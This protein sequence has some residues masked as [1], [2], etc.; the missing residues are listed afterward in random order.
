MKI[1][2]LVL[3]LIISNTVFVLT[4]D[5]TAFGQLDRGFNNEISLRDPN[6]VVEEYVSNLKYPVMIDFI[7]NDML[8]IE[9]DGRIKII[10]DGILKSEPILELEVGISIEEGLIGILVVDNDVYLHYTTKN[11]EDNTVSNWF[12]KYEWNGEEL[13]EPELLMSF[14][15]GDGQHNA[16][17]MT[18]D[19][20]GVVY[21]AIGDL[22]N[23]KGVFQNYPLGNTDNTGTI[24]TLEP[25]EVFAVGIRNSYGLDFDPLTK[26]LW[27]TE[28]G[29]EVF[30]EINLV[31]KNFNSGWEK[32]M[33]PATES[34]LNLLSNN[35]DY[36]YSDPEFSW[37]RPI[38]VTG[39]HFVEST[40]FPKYHNTV[41]VGSFHDGTLY[42]FVL[43]D[44]RDGFVF[45]DEQL[46]DLVLNTDDQTT[47]IIFGTG[48]A[49]ITDIKE[50]PNGHIYI[51][52]IGNGVI[53]EITPNQDIEKIEIDCINELNS[54]KNL[55]GCDFSNKSLANLDLSNRDLSFTNLRNSDLTNVN[56]SNTKLIG[57]NFIDAKI[58]NTDFSNAILD[59]AILD[60]QMLENSK[61]TET[62]F[63]STNLK[64]VNLSNVNLK[65]S[66]FERA[67]LDESVLIGTNFEG[68]NLLRTS[69]VEANLS[70]SNFQHADLTF[71]ILDNS[72]LKNSDLGNTRL[73]KTS[74][75]NADLSNANLKNSDNHASK[76]VNSNLTNV[77]FQFSRLSMVN[78]SNADFSNANLYNIFPINSIFEN[79]NLSL[80]KI[81][82]CLEHDLMSRILNKVLR[83]IR[84]NNIEFLQ[85]V[86][87]IIV[88]ICN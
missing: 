59:S 71:A 13:I 2:L 60:G 3:L 79:S 48:F 42:K 14:H 10:K 53:Y 37:E 34:K 73:W 45:E 39:I 43:N 74:I 77:D 24:M 38:G 56:F 8:V 64:K 85:P 15:K 41:L 55:S 67:I 72:I 12:Y 18:H 80:T 82:T 65:N 21:V 20:N 47:E 29:P 1:L 78:F 4:I 25:T 66:N 86:E 50:G 6:L 5:S 40:L 52:S 58:S 76:F 17:I 62:S 63:L 81:N 7:G 69:I 26:F 88:D 49:G 19:E 83:E 57:V 75:N 68:S 28:N 27:D 30:D 31:P 70:D 51:V 23:R 16:G 9:K 84:D 44:N 11:T 33:G 54:G 46:Q 36:V 35:E 32:I 22:G 87:N 61:F